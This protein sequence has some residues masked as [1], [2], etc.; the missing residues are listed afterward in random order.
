[1]LPAIPTGAFVVMVI[2]GLW[3]CLW[4]GRVRA[5]GLAPL[6][7]GALV[8]ASSPVPDL[9]VSGDGRHVA[10]IAEDGMPLMLRERAGD[11]TRSLFAESA[12][13]DGETGWIEDRPAANCNANACAF[14]II[15]GGRLWRILAFRSSY[16]APWQD[17]VDACAKA[18]IVVADRRLPRA[19]APRWLKLDRNALSQSGGLAIELRADPVVHSVADRVGLH[20]WREVAVTSRSTPRARFPT[21]R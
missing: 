11:F 7:A 8:A 15:R 6:A 10:L 1:M 19:C 12:G 13:F 2:G 5:W 21:G 18:D 16:L 4:R 3:C 14:G 17:T 9:L 20:P